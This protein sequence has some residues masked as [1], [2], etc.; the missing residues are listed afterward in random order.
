MTLRATLHTTMGDIVME[1]FD[2]QTPEAVANFKGL[3]EGTKPYA[4]L[5]ASGGMSGPYYDG[6]TI[7][8]VAKWYL[9]QMGDPTGTGQGGPGYMFPDEIV[10]GLTFDRPWLVGTAGKGPQS[11]GSQFFITVDQMPHLDGDYTLFGEV[12][13]WPSRDVVGTINMVPTHAMVPV[14]PIIV[15][16]VTFE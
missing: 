10:E 2:D 7:H 6:M 1:L 13:D 9:I 12:T 16:S 4:G 8:C 5:N 11:H 15:S 14:D 3:A